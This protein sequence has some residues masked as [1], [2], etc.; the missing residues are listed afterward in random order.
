MK[1]NKL[2]I[3][4]AVAACSTAVMADDEKID[5]SLSVKT[6]HNSLYVANKDTNLTLQAANSPIIGLTVLNCIQ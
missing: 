3:A 2:L 4:F 6:W 5:Y 1:M